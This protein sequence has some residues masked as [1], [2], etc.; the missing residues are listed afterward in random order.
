MSTEQNKAVVRRFIADIVVGG[1]YGAVDE[2]LAP[3]YVN[4]MMPGADLG[5]F[6]AFAMEMAKAIQESH[7]DDLTLI[8]E[9]DEVVAR[10]NYRIT[11]TNG[12]KLSA[13]NLTYFRLDGGKIVEDDPMMTPDLHAEL[14]GLMTPPVGP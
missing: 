11:L 5:S 4:A 14:A 12:K 6:R 9:G 13:R 1:N 2:L 3:N 8:A 7:A 10:F